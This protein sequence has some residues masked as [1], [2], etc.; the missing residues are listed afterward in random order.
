MP[1][2]FWKHACHGSPG[3]STSDS[4]CHTCGKTGEFAGWHYTRH[5]AM[6]RYQTTYGLKPIGPHRKLTDQL[7]SA[8]L[9]ACGLCGG[10]GLEDGG[11]A[12]SLILSFGRRRTTFQT[13]SMLTHESLRDAA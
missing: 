3:S 13:S 5:E 8:A 10:E 2:R 12:P 1:S 4:I 6:A 11:S 9:E 7:F